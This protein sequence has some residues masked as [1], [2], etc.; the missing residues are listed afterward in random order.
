[1]ANKSIHSFKYVGERPFG[2]IL[3]TSAKIEVHMG[4]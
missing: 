3:E 4:K 2:G 1:M